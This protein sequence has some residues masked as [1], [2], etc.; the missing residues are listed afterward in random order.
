M[1]ALTV[2]LLTSIIVLYCSDSRT[3]IC[4]RFFFFLV[5]RR[6]PRSTGSHT[7]CSYTTLVR[8]AGLTDG[9]EPPLAARPPPPERADVGDQR[10]PAGRCDARDR[11][12]TRL[13][14]SH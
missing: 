3:V 8:S 5:I 2:L 7:L 14:S 10:H 11:K 4:H 1:C 12:S 9:D 6:P 13:N